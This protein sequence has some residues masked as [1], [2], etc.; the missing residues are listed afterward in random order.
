[1]LG[2]TLP[3][4]ILMSNTTSGDWA[5]AKVARLA[6][7]MKTTTSGPRTWVRTVQRTPPEFPSP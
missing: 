7:V 3:F 1:M 5:T 4:S 2:G 6:I